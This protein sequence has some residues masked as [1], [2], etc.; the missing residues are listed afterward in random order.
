MRISIRDLTGTITTDK[1]LRGKRDKEL[2]SRDN[3]RGTWRVSRCV[4]E[5]HVIISTSEAFF[6]AHDS[7]N[8]AVL[9]LMLVLSCK[10]L[11]IFSSYSFGL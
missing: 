9:D 3:L 4:T 2:E 5:E 7:I 1:C 8:I 6:L 11:N 10:I